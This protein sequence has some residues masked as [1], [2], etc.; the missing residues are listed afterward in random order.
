MQHKKN[1]QPLET[2][3]FIFF[4]NH[5]EKENLN[6]RIKLF[7]VHVSLFKK[8]PPTHIAEQ[9]TNKNEY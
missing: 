2:H 7:F 9:E 4:A 5:E 6:M 3:L 8:I 1:K